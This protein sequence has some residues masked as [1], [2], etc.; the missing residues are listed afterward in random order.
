[1]KN[2]VKRLA[3]HKIV[4]ELAQSAKDLLIE[5]GYDPVYGARP[6]KRAIQHYIENPL[7]MEI[8]KGNIIDGTTLRVEA[9]GDKMVFQS[10]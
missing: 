10:I 3:E 7:A 8:L 6:L 4:L 1:M 9:Q 5:N 2:L